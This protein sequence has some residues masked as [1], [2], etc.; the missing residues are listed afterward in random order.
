M[1]I[2]I[3]TVARQ[4]RLMEWVDQIR[5][6]QSRPNGMSVDE[7]CHTHDISKAN[8]YYRLSQVRKAC[9]LLWSSIF[10]TFVAPKCLIIGFTISQFFQVLKS[11]LTGVITLLVLR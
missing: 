6:C 7:W 4:Y 3:A 2:G 8:Y 10:V 11:I 1:E 5:D 9:L